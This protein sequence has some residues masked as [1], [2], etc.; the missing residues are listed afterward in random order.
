MSL[1][2]LPVQSLEDYFQETHQYWLPANS[3]DE[4]Y[5]QLAQNKYREILR[6]YIR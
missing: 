4:L 3:E 2:P 6:K 1:L 5:Y